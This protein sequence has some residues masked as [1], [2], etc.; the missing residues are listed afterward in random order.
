MREF[1]I[2][3]V[4]SLPERKRIASKRPRKGEKLGRVQPPSAV[5]AYLTVI[6]RYPDTV[7]KALLGA[8]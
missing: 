6:E 7:E 3:G 1:R 2:T 5:R 8:A 4:V